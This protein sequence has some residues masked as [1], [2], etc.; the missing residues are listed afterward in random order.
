M[1]SRMYNPIRI[2]N[3][4]YIVFWNIQFKIYISIMDC[5]QECKI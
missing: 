3:S 5:I 4:K 2:K 1:Y